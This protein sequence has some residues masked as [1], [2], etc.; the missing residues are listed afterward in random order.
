MWASVEVGADV[1]SF[2]QFVCSCLRVPLGLR[3]ACVESIKLYTWGCLPGHSSTSHKGMLC[4]LSPVLIQ[5]EPFCLVGTKTSYGPARA[6][7]GVF[8]IRQLQSESLL[9]L[10]ASL[11]GRSHA[12]LWRL[13]YTGPGKQSCPF[14]ELR[15]LLTW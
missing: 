14:G 9:A 3:S 12:Q 15:R 4:F 2:E 1:Y 11:Y 8:R 5:R 6:L 7:I 13:T 10:R